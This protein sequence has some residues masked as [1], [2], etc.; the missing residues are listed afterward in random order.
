MRLHDLQLVPPYFANLGLTQLQLLLDAEFK[1]DTLSNLQI[2]QR[3][4]D[5]PFIV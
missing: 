4:L 3:F 2:P 1:Q 5:I